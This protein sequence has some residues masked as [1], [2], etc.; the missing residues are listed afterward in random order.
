M[1]ELL[2]VNTYLRCYVVHVALSAVHVKVSL[3]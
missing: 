1:L 2:N 3:I